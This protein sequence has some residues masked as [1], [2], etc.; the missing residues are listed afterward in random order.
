MFDKIFESEIVT[1]SLIIVLLSWIISTLILILYCLN[2]YYDPS[3]EDIRY[4][5]SIFV[6]L[7]TLISILYFF[8]GN[9]EAF[10]IF[11][12]IIVISLVFRI[13]HAIFGFFFN[14]TDYMDIFI[15]ILL[16]LSVIFI[17]KE[18]LYLGMFDKEFSKAIS[19]DKSGEKDKAL[20]IYQNLSK[21][22]KQYPFLYYNMSLILEDMGKYEEALLN[23]NKTLKLEPSYYKY[24]YRKG[25]LLYN[26]GK[27]DESLLEIDKVLK[28]EHDY[29][30]ALHLKGI[31]FFYLEKYDE[32]LKYI[33]KALKIEENPQ[34]LKVKIDILNEL[35]RHN[36]ELKCCDRLIKIDS[37]NE[38]NYITKVITLLSLNCDK[39]A[40][41]LINQIL[42]DNNDNI[43]AWNYKSIIFYYKGNY[44]KALKYSNNALSI[45]KSDLWVLSIKILILLQLAKF[46]DVSKCLKEYYMAMDKN[47]K[48]EMAWYLVLKRILYYKLNENEEALKYSNKCL[49]I[50]NKNVD[51][52]LYKIQILK[53][54]GHEKELEKCCKSTL[55]LIDETLKTN[56]GDV[57]LK[58]DKVDVYI[59]LKECDKA[60]KLLK[61]IEIDSSD[62]R[63][64]NYK[65][66]LLNKIKSFDEALEN[67][68]KA[69]AIDPENP[70][71]LNNKSDVLLE[72]NR[73]DESLDAVNKA[74]EIIPDYWISLYNKAY[75][76]EKL[77][78]YDEALEYYNRAFEINPYDKELQEDRENLLKKTKKE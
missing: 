21:E 33:D 26:L 66:I 35:K 74:L 61:S 16:S 4:I 34:I 29:H 6:L 8:K 38:D 14:F 32:A 17:Y 36:E 28:L 59:N 70:Y 44:L 31:N 55:S 69:L 41:S 63:S 60:I 43:T 12:A 11:K 58:L 49:K 9:N 65:G 57:E 68:D 67:Y 62:K 77:E 47:N 75:A 15:I 5:L 72:L 20:K 1:I 3:L 19:L 30:N 51:N 46:K 18:F 53:E 76:L 7:I 37:N 71:F 52:Y 78:R 48:K 50:D 27:Y 45:T 73:F 39:K 64:F 22:N 42:K 56:N 25:V 10:T 13:F 54:L 24:L 40:L 23:I 2:I